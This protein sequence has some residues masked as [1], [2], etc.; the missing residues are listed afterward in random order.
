MAAAD[1]QPLKTRLPGRV[2][3]PGADAYDRATRPRNTSARQRPAAVVVAETPDDVAGCLQAAGVAGLRVVVQATGH[4]AGADIGDEALLL[5]TSR[6]NAVDVDPDRRV[7]RAQADATFGAVNDAAYRHGLLAPGGTA[8][9]V[10]VAGY[11]VHGGVGWLTRPHGLASAALTAVDV[12]DGTGRRLHADGEQH[13]DVLWAYRGGGGVGIATELEM[14][15]FP[16]DDLH[17]GYVLWGVEHAAAVIPAWGTALSALDPAVT[18][19]IGLLHAPDAPSVPQALRGKPVVHLSAATVAG[20]AAMRSLRAILS[21]LPTP[22]IDTLGPCDAGRLSMIHL[23]PPTPVPALGEGRWLTGEAGTRALEILTA[24]GDD[25]PLGEVELRHVAVAHS[26]VPGAETSCPGQVL[27]HA[28]GAAPD[29]P[30]RMRVASALRAVL[31]AAG[32][33]DTGRSAAA[34]R[35]GQPSA[36]DALAPDIRARVDSVRRAIDP[37]G[38]ITPS[39]SLR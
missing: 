7:V 29:A 17:A 20:E 16:A 35:D 8:P 15:L 32:P 39:R 38:I 12:V 18:S 13:T 28:T 22:A 19:A 37:Y 14:R 3:E 2:F 33:V 34:F 36:P 4:G 10:A 24:A 1:T 21:T 26:P 31:S 25:S 9:D 11:T 27:L 5:D 6:L 30:T 23:D